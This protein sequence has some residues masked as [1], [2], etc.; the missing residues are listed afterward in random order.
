MDGLLNTVIEH[1]D[2][3]ISHLNWVCMF[4]GFHSFGLYCHNDTLR[5]LGRTSEL[6]SGEGMALVP[7]LDLSIL[8]SCD[9]ALGAS[10]APRV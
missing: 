8:K 6:F 2:T 1:R 5:S 3:I 4:L 10:P 7:G 9:L